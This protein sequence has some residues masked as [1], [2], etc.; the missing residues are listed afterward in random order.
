MNDVEVTMVGNVLT[1]P[2]WRRTTNT[3]TS[4]M[5]FRFASNSRRFDRNTGRWV[6]GDSLRVKV[7]CWR[8]L[9]DNGHDSISLGDPL[10]VFGRMYS[11]DWVDSEDKRRTSYEVDAITIGHDL[12]RG[13][14]KFIRRK[15]LAAIGIVEDAEHDLSIGGEMSIRVDGPAAADPGAGA[16][17]D[18]D[19][20]DDLDEE[21]DETQR[22][23]VA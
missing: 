21:L 17:E 7:A 8:A 19:E 9:G 22:E 11:R 6:D 5:T 14:A 23:L 15:P 12:S 18:E 16:I 13:T 1:E 4:V 10:I 20:D 2:E 3:G